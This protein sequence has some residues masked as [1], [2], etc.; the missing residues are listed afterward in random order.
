[1]RLRELFKEHGRFKKQA[2]SLKKWILKEFS[3]EKQYEKFVDSIL[4]TLQ[5]EIKEE[6]IQ[7]FG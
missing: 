6:E 7:V 2:Q 4:E 1:M 3:E 5:T